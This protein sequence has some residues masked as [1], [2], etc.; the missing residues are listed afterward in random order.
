VTGLIADNRLF[1]GGNNT[2]IIVFEIST[3]LTQPLKRLASIETSSGIMKM[4]KLGK[5]IIL[6]ERR[7]YL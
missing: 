5:N 4:M 3:S 6:G 7:G 2:K 1:L